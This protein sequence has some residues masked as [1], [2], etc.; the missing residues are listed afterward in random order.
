MG[1]IIEVQA[2]ADFDILYTDCIMYHPDKLVIDEIKKDFCVIM[3]IES[4]KGLECSIL[5][6]TKEDFIAYLQM[7]GFKKLTTNKIYFS[8]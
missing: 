2:W 6:D 7:A 5:H 4:F 8:D 3:K 1:T